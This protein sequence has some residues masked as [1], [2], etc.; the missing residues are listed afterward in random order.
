M[1]FT[2]ISSSISSS[3]QFTMKAYAQFAVHVSQYAQYTLCIGRV[4]SEYLYKMSLHML[5]SYALPEFVYVRTSSRKLWRLRYNHYQHWNSLNWI[6]LHNFVWIQ[7]YSNNFALEAWN[8]YSALVW[9][10]SFISFEW[11]LF[12]AVAL[13]H[14]AIYN[15]WITFVIM[16]WVRNLMKI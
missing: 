13:H 9:M 5:R 1:A 6:F 8:V 16:I 2:D 7:F 11:F 4:H 14:F 12:C 3:R 10:F 15:T